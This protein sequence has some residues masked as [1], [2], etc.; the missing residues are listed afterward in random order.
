MENGSEEI[1]PEALGSFICLA[2]T[3]QRSF[4]TCFMEIFEI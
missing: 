3:Y 1:L 2:V 4:N